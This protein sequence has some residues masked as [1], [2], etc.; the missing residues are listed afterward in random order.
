M[1]YINKFHRHLESAFE[2]QDPELFD[3]VFEIEG[4]KLYADKLIL[5]INSSTFKSMLS[6]RWI[7]KNDA[8]KI[9]TYKFDDFKEML[10]FIY[11]GK[12]NVTNENIFT[13]LDMSEFYQIDNLKGL[14][15]EYLSK[16][17]LNLANI[18]QLIETSNKYSLIKMKEPIRTFI[19]QNFANMAKFEGFLKGDKSIIKEIVSKESYLSKYHENIFQSIYE[20]S[21]NQAIKKQKESNDEN[22][23]MNDAIK[24]EMQK[25]LPNIQFN[26]MKLK[27]L[28]EFV[29]RRGFLF[30]YNELADFLVNSNSYVKVKITNSNGQTIFGDLPRDNCAAEFIKTLMNR[31]SVNADS[32]CICWKPAFTVPSTQSPLKKKDGVKWYL[33]YFNNGFIGVKYTA[34]INYKHYLL[35]EMY[36]ETD[37][38]FTHMCKIEIE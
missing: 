38:Q 12:C 3:I 7:S 9:E 2:S 10:I 5:S 22:F 29:V 28:H 23:D 17:E 24:N 13:I 30:A 34:D 27:F 20:W 4:K 36:S 6:D 18:F 21:E 37:F 31:I 35:A 15:E 33:I 16:M 25:L 26:K 11:S 14:C 19:F 32:S 1:N 8:I